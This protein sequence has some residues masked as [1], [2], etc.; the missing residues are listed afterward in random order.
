MKRH[1]FDGVEYKNGVGPEPSSTTGTNAST[2]PVSSAPSGSPPRHGPRHEL[3]QANPGIAEAPPKGHDAFSDMLFGASAS[4]QELPPGRSE[5]GPEDSEY[6]KVPENRALVLA[7]PPSQLLPEKFKNSRQVSLAHRIKPTS[8]ANSTFASP[9]GDLWP[10]APPGRPSIIFGHEKSPSQVADVLPHE[11][12][13]TIWTRDL[14]PKEQT[15]F[16]RFM[17]QYAASSEYDPDSEVE[18]A[19]RRTQPEYD[20]PDAKERE[21]KILREFFPEMVRLYIGDPSTLLK[22]SPKGYQVMKSIFGGREYIGG[23]VTDAKGGR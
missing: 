21:S 2:L 7:T 10:G 14:S 16:I 12:G 19:Y 13:H 4:A 3:K 17:R 18:K 11:L 15:A 23:R 8:G 5:L 22:E 6:G 20:E 9:D 1:V